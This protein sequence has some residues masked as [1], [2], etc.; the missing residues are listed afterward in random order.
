LN[1]LRIEMRLMDD[2]KACEVPG[3]FIKTSSLHA[4]G[5]IAYWAILFLLIVYE[6]T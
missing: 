4:V 5:L 3:G 2:S 1:R 6:M